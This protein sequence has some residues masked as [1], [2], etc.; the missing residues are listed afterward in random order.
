[1]AS[2]SS[3][4]RR[5]GHYTAIATRAG[6][7]EGLEEPSQQAV[8]LAAEVARPPEVGAVGR[9]AVSPPRPSDR[10]RRCR[11]LAVRSDRGS[12]GPRRRL[13]PGGARRGY[14]PTTRRS[15]ATRLQGGARSATRGHARSA[16]VPRHDAAR[17]P[18]A[19]LRAH[20]L[21]SLDVPERQQHAPLSVR[22]ARPSGTRRRAS[23][24]RL[25][26]RGYAS[27][28]HRARWGRRWRSGRRWRRSDRSACRRW[29]GQ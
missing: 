20:A 29:W 25:A 3:A 9:A 8:A 21:G 24:Y 2:G 5:V 23:S 18:D 19:L 28:R 7:V 1:M 4:R 14:P 15:T 16:T 27:S 10:E 26:S 13:G 22:R 17:F 12:T 11:P 6:A